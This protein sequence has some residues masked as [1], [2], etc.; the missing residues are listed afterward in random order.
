LTALRF[1]SAAALPVRYSQARQLIARGV[2]AFMASSVGRLFDAVAALLGFT[3]P[4][5]FEAQAAIWLEHH[6]SRATISALVPFGYAH[7]ELDWKL[8]LRSVIDS[9]LA[10]SRLGA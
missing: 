2:R 5:T 1:A 8:A 3:G 9:R 7:G 10:A 6:A 4:V